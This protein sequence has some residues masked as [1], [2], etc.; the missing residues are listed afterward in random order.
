[1]LAPLTI[2]TSIKLGFKWT[3]VKQDSFDEIKWIVACKAFGQTE[4]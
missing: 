4:M 3:Q 2:L 1:M